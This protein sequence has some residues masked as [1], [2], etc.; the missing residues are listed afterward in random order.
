MRK[1]GTGRQNFGSS[2]N[3]S[4]KK[5]KGKLGEDMLRR[6]GQGGGRWSVQRGKKSWQEAYRPQKKVF[7]EGLKK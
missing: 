3:P 7:G 6:N 5:P 4:D 2:R 1:K